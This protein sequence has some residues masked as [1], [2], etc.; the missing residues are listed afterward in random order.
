MEAINTAQPLLAAPVKPKAKKPAPRTMRNAW[1]EHVAKTRKRLQRGNKEKV[2]HRE[3]MR[4]A[5]TNWAPQ[6]EKLQKKLLRAKKKAERAKKKA[7]K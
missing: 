7:Q 4:I 2:T 3:A 1:F 6:K 5:S